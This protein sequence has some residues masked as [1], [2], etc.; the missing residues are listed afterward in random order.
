MGKRGRGARGKEKRDEYMVLVRNMKERYDLGDEGVY[1]R[2]KLK[3]IRG[4]QAG[5]RGVK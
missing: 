1:G 5:R 2:T 3:L 4:N